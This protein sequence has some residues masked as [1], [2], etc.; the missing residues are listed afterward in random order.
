M[1]YQILPAIGLALANLA[2]PAIARADCQPASSVEEALAAAEI[3]FVGTVV[4][5]VEGESR[6]GFS[7]EEVW[8]G[9]L[10][11][12]TEVRGL[13]DAGLSEDDRRWTLG[14][15]YLVIPYVDRGVL[16]D[17]ICSATVEWRDELAALRPP[18]AQ[19]PEEG[20]SGSDDGIPGA[21]LAVAA[22][23]G[24]LIV[25]GLIAFGRRSPSRPV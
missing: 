2:F 6:A 23:V 14:V 25:V 17:N 3:A 21:V 19:S 20:P 16:R 24:V 13:R 15:R 9:D 7:V 11:A 8:V 1:R 18:G 12:A 5:A 22:A 4:A 10:P